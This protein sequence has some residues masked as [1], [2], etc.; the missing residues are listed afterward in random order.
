MGQDLESLI[1]CPERKEE[2]AQNPVYRV[3]PGEDRFLQELNRNHTQWCNVISDLR[4]LGRFAREN[5]DT[6][7]SC[8]TRCNEGIW[9]AGVKRRNK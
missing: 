6:S 9:Q 2:S 7:N 5:G 8:I 1:R 3:P 4:G